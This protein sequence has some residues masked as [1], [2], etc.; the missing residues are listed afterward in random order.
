MK[1]IWGILAVGL[2]SLT[3]CGSTEAEPANE[4]APITTSAA[5]QAA[6][7]TKDAAEGESEIL[8]SICEDARGDGETDLHSARLLSDGTLMFLTYELE[9]DVPSSGTVLYSVTAWNDAG[10]AGYQIG[11]KFQNGQEI[12]NFVYDMT[13]SEQENI[14][15]GAVH[16]DGQVS[17][18]YPLDSLSGLGDSFTWS[19]TVTVDGKDVDRCPDGQEKTQFPNT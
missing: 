9:D 7:P 14:T 13:A 4:A 8:E 5:T 12:A 16:A 11:T 19:A 15:N 2:L 10:D 1:K 3:A 17:T 18:R 6:T